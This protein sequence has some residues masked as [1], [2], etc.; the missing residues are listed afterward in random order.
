MHADYLLIFSPFFLVFFFLLVLNR[1]FD[2]PATVLQAQRSW[3]PMVFSH[4]SLL[5]SSLLV[6]VQV[7]LPVRERYTKID[8]DFMHWFEVLKVSEVVTNP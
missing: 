3:V 8:V 2:S 6:Y 4:L 1:L 7:Q 5:S